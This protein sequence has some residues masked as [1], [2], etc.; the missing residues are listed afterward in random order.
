MTLTEAL[1]SISKY[2]DTLY[3]NKKGFMV[4]FA[5][6]WQEGPFDHYFKQDVFPDIS[7]EELIPT[8]DE[9][10]DLAKRFLAANPEVVEV[11]VIDYNYEWVGQNIYRE[12][13][14]QI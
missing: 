8:Y 14:K 11:G 10:L 6:V 1:E 7:C 2:E 3:P 4:F 13:Q 5:K 9:A 12:H